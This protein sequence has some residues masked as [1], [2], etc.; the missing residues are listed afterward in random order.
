MVD[1]VRRYSAR[2]LA[3]AAVNLAVWYWFEK[4]HSN[5]LSY[6]DLWPV[7]MSVCSALLLF[8]NLIVFMVVRGPDAAPRE[9]RRGAVAISSEPMASGE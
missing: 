7:R 9:T 5:T 3:M 6:A 4:S 8:D 2:L 1:F